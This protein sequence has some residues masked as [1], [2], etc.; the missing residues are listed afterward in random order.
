VFTRTHSG[1]GTT[2]ERLDWVKAKVHLFAEILRQVNVPNEKL[3]VAAHAF[4]E[5]IKMFAV[6]SKHRGFGEEN[7]WRVVYMRDRDRDNEFH[8]ADAASSR[9]EKKETSVNPRG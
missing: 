7:E 6:F 4:F 5:R 8:V 2:E 3:W 1:F 9:Q